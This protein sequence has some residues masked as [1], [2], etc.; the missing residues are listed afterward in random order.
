MKKSNAQRTRTS[1]PHWKLATRGLIA[2]AAMAAAAALSGC[3]SKLDDENYEKIT[4]GMTLDQVTNFMGEGTQE[5]SGGTTI[6]SSGLAGGTN[7][8]QAR[9][10]TYIWKEGDK[11]F[12]IEFMDDKVVGKRRRGFDG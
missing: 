7:N 9:G 1:G 11:M 2:G 8:A 3:E 5:V 10:K 6:S 12:I 4:V